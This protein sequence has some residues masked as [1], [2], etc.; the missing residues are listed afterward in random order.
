LT[1]NNFVNICFLIFS[2]K[3]CGDGTNVATKKLFNFCFTL[4]DQGAIAKSAAGNFTL[5]LFDIDV[6]KYVTLKECLSE[7][8]QSLRQLKNMGKIIIKDKEYKLK[9]LLGGDMSFLH[10]TMGL[11]ACN[12][13]HPCFL[14]KEEAKSF[15]KASAELKAE[16]RTLA[17]AHKLLS[18]HSQQ[19]KS[20]KENLAKTA[21]NQLQGYQDESIFDFIEFEDIVFDTLHMLLRITGNIFKSLFKYFSLSK[22]FS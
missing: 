6:E 3:L 5:G 22:K 7:I 14:C 21:T 16:L 11:N 13:N 9:L 15:H 20:K 17:D 1:W 4:P 12:S 2:V 18:M 8:N 10:T 19:S